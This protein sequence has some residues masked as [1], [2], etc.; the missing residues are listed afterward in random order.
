MLTL[1][2]C[3]AYEIEQD[4]AQFR[5]GE[6][7]LCPPETCAKVAWYNEQRFARLMSVPL[8]SPELMNRAAG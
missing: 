2:A 6:K 3:N 7:P 4:T 1:C 8:A 5:R